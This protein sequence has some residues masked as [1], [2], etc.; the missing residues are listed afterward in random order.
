MIPGPGIFPGEGM[1]YPL[2]YAWTS[3][4]AQM[5]KNLPAMQEIWV[6]KMPW[7]KAW[8]PTPVFFPR[9]SHRQRS[10]EGYSPL[11]RK[12]SDASKYSTQH[13]SI[14]PCLFYPSLT[15]HLHPAFPPSLHK[16]NDLR[17]KNQEGET[18]KYIILKARVPTLTT[19]IHYSFGSFS[20]SNQRRKINERNPNWKRR[21]KYLTVCR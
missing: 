18:H 1:G 9:E 20:H 21:S 19:T 13:I 2:Q 15:P 17:L 7:R 4:E 8:Q 6:G 14:Y 16:M 3:L 10:L 11:G 12:E 5:V